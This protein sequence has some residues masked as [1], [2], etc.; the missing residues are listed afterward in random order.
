[1][2]KENGTRK[3]ENDK[4]VTTNFQDT[5]NSEI[6]PNIIE[7]VTSIPSFGTSAVSLSLR[8]EKRE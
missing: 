3:R 2:N 5:R 4:Q 6:I 1:M 7:K 8:K